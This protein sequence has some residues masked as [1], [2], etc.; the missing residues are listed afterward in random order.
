M[1]DFFTILSLILIA[2][3]WWIYNYKRAFKKYVLSDFKGKSKFFIF[4]YKF[5]ALTYFEGPPGG[6][7]MLNTYNDMNKKNFG[8]K[9]LRIV[10]LCVILSMASASFLSSTLISK[11]QN[12]TTVNLISDF[13]NNKI[14]IIYSIGELTKIKHIKGK[15]YAIEINGNNDKNKFTI[16]LDRDE[17]IAS[18]SNVKIGYFK[19]YDDKIVSITAGNKKIKTFNI[20]EYKKNLKKS[21]LKRKNFFKYGLFSLVLLL[22]L[23]WLRYRLYG[24]DGIDKLITIKKKEFQKTI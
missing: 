15:R 1:I 24:F 20:N 19:K 7:S 10:G 16:S 21:I 8:K 17:K 9:Y 22:L 14:N 13:D 11:Y 6:G 2:F 12:K 18:K 4:M 23:L 3:Q 5:F